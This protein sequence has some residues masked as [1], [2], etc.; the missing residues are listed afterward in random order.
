[1]SELITTGFGEALPPAPRHAITFHLPKWANLLRLLEKDQ[2]LFNALKNTY[3][4][5]LPKPDVKALAAALGEFLNLPP[6]TAVVIFTSLSSASE[7]VEFA[8]QTPRAEGMLDAPKGPDPVA[9]DE[10]SI[11]AL[12]VA[13][14]GTKLFAVVLPAQNFPNV[15][16]FWQNAGLGIQS[17]LAEQCLD[18]LDSLEEVTKDCSVSPR[19]ESPGHVEVKERIA[20]LVERA[21]VGGP[22]PVQV[23]A[24]DIYL[25]QTGMT[26]IYRVHTWLLKANSL[27]AKTA[28][29]G[30]AFYTTLQIFHEYGTGNKLIGPGT[31]EELIHLEAFLESEKND[32]RK[33]QA[34]WFEF[35][36]NPSLT[37]PNLSRLRDLAD[38]YG[39]YLI[40]DD[41]IGSFC[42]IDLLGP[43]G[44]DIVVT[45]LTKSFSGYADVMG[46][47]AI[48]NPMASRYAE[49]KDLFTQNYEL[50]Y[51]PLDAAVLASNS[52]DYLVRA[53]TFNTNTQTLVSYFQSKVSDPKSCITGVLYPNTNP[54]FKA[55]FDAVKRPTTPEFEPGYGCLFS[56]E[57]ESVEKLE[58][59]YDCVNLHVGP[60]LGAHRTIMIS[61]VKGLYGKQMEWARRFGLR[62]TMLRI[63]TGLEDVEGLIGD[64]ENALKVVDGLRGN[65]ANDADF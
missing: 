9:R 56:I 8:T 38:T 64:F 26:S 59:F 4:R 21:P 65:F 42:N 6:G 49:L 24:D 12:R 55:N 52:R 17:R 32:G 62:E 43:S 23:Q 39:C 1:M 25:F 47:S 60:H 46:A 27:E 57:F 19:T 30:F 33:V 41:T 53:K 44:A 58:V 28:F 35:P 34:I 15:L 11:R 16:Q 13:K 51:C 40:A 22:R 29:F 10:I 36:S 45:S 50:D 20:G 31:D 63:A 2:T 54:V 18:N 61:Y 48:L 14:T 37:V 5:M 7:C 3:P